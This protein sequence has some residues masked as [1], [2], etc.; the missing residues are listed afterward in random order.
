MHESPLSQTTDD[1]LADILFAGEEIEEEITVDDARIAVT[2]HR[3]LAFMPGG[4]DRQF[5]HADRPNVVDAS[6]QTTGRRRYL[7]WAVRSVVYGAVLVGGGYLLHSSGVLSTFDGTSVPNNQAVGD[8][9]R[10]IGTFSNLFGVLTDVLVL[11]GVVLLAVAAALAGL[12]YASRS[13]E[14]VI[15]RAGREP[16]RVPVGGEQAEA[17]ASRIRSLVGTSSKPRND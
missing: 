6:V 13:E 7:S 15:E 2:S 17:A 16:I 1:R 10:M 8:V 4:G 14:L 3:V 11:V 5:D 12:Y 9:G